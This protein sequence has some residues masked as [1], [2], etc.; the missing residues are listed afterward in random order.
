MLHAMIVSCRRSGAPERA[1]APDNAAASPSVGGLSAFTSSASLLLW[2]IGIA[3]GGGLARGGAGV[4]VF[5]AGPGAP[6]RRLLLRSSRRGPIGPRIALRLGKPSAVLLVLEPS[7][8][9]PA[10]GGRA[11][12]R[13]MGTLAHLVERAGTLAG[14]QGVLGAAGGQLLL[15]EPQQGAEGELQQP[16]A[17]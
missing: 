1:G 16:L 3:I 5:P 2:G 13:G 7:G 12:A 10:A 8:F 11:T 4:G 14:V 17:L 6:R 9:L 15:A